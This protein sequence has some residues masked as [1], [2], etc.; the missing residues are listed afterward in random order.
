MADALVQFGIALFGLTA[1]WWALGNS[2]TL[3]RWAPIVG[4]CG[5]V[6]W[7]AFAWLAHRK[8]VDVRGLLV[9]CAAYSVVYARWILVW[10][11]LPI[12][13]SKR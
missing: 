12:Y 6:F 8:G 10:W 5:Q 2:V 9:L 11:I 1:L 7:L 13:R 4:L 3:R